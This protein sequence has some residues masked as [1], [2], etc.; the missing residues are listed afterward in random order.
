MCA[1]VPPVFPNFGWPCGD[2]S[3]YEK[4]DVTNPFLD[5]SLPD[6]TVAHQNVSSEKNRIL[7]LEN[8]VVMRKLNH[9]ASERDR[10]KKINAM[11]SSLRSCL[12]ASD[13]SVTNKSNMFFLI[14]YEIWKRIITS[15]ICTGIYQFKHLTDKQKQHFQLSFFLFFF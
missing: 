8:P 1:L 6:L 11:F 15:F 9:N 4:D 14:T 7:E 3:F 13:Q 10:R 5:F 2:H 12:P